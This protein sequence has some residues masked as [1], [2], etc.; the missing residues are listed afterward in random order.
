LVGVEVNMVV[1]NCLEALALYES[2]FEVDRH[3]VTNY[4][5]GLNEAVFSIYGVRFHLL[6]ENP[7]YSLIAPKAGEVRS[8]WMNVLVPDIQETYKKALAAGCSEIQPITEIK[9]FGVSNAI[10]ADP[11]GYTWLLHQ[12]HRPV[13][14]EERCAIYEEKMKDGS[15]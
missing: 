12:I 2:V 10:F 13:S 3:E 14:F 1:S 6:D 11:F 9:E 7:S 5:Q 15:H 4:E 8:I